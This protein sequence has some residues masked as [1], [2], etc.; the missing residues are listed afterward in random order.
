MDEFPVIESLCL[1]KYFWD[2]H[3]ANIA[4]RLE[5]VVSTIFTFTFSAAVPRTQTFVQTEIQLKRLL[6]LKSE[7]FPCD[8]RIIL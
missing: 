4:T 6:R 1:R 2:R 7:L 5:K 3:G 8:L